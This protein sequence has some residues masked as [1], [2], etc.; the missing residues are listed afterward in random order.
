MRKDRWWM[1]PAAL[2]LVGLQFAAL[3]W[4]HESGGAV[5]HE[6]HVGV[7]AFVLL[8]FYA[9]A[10]WSQARLAAALGMPVGALAACSAIPF[11]SFGATMYLAFAPG[12]DGN[13]GPPRRA[14]VGTCGLLVALMP[15]VVWANVLDFCT[16]EIYYGVAVSL[17]MIVLPLHIYCIA[18]IANRVGESP[19]LFILLALIG[20]PLFSPTIPLAMVGLGWAVRSRGRTS[21]A[22]PS[23]PVI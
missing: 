1:I 10:A 12:A 20:A 4:I 15:G 16:L 11:L 21:V 7:T 8:Q 6:S 14:A 19:W 18:R 5:A 22:A 2:G 9:F 3:R 23:T 17:R 13:G